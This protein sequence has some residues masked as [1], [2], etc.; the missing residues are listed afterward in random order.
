MDEK[1]EKPNGKYDIP[2]GVHYCLPNK[3]FY[4]IQ[5][6]NVVV[7]G[8]MLT[9]EDCILYLDDEEAFTFME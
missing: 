8:K 9:K 6:E 4:R 7:N 3:K 5:V 2:I 1:I